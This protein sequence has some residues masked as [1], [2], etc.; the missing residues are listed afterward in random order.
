MRELFDFLEE[1]YGS[2]EKY[3]DQVSFD[4]ELRDCVRKIICM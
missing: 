2:I 1:K 3:L 4:Q